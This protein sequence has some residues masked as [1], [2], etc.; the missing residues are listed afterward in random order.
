MIRV[1]FTPGGL[2]VYGNECPLTKTQKELVRLLLARPGV[3]F[4]WRVISEWLIKRRNVNATQTRVGQYV[5]ECNLAFVANA[6]P[7][8]IIFDPNTQDY[9]AIVETEKE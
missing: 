2:A 4:N 5:N 8:E 6:I 7:L 9:F 1:E 3:R